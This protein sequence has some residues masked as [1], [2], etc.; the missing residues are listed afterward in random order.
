MNEHGGGGNNG[1]AFDKYIIESYRVESNRM[2][3]EKLLSF[4]KNQFSDM[5]IYAE[6]YNRQR[7]PATEKQYV[8]VEREKWYEKRTV[9]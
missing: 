7:Q 6:L 3:S 2:C 8:T 5:C 9:E 4:K 1:C